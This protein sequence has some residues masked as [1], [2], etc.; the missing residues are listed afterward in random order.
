MNE[1]VLSRPVAVADI[2]RR[3]DVR[4]TADPQERAALA[5]EYDLLEVLSLQATA[6]LSSAD[7]GVDVSGRITADI[8]QSCVVTLLP[9]EQHIDEPF[10]VRFVRP[11]SPELE[12][13]MK[14][15]AEVLVDPG[16]P[17]PPE[18]LDGPALDLGAVVEE[19]FVLAIDPY[20]RVP[21]A[22]LP[23]EATDDE[24]R[25]SPFAVLADLKRKRS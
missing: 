13:I 17:D 18:V 5:A 15:H 9:V 2:Q 20:P 1:G 24:G 25:P 3:S 11:G 6:T 16:A 8:V 4:V 10:S 23:E 12:V 19:A 21:G 7:G 14:P 22:A